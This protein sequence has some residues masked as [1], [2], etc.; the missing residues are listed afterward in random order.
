MK[1][2]LVIQLARF[3]D[4]IQTKRLLA[5]LCA[6]EDATVHLCVDASLEALARLVYPGVEVH[7]IMAH[8]TGLNGREATLRVLTNNRRT[9][10]ALAST[11]FETVYNL[12]F[13]GLNFRLAALFDPDRVEGYAWKNGQEMT[14]TWPAM[15]MRWTNYR[16]IGM[17][18]VDF[19]AGYCPDRIAPDTVNPEATPKGGG[20]GVV[21]AGRESRRSLPA[22]LLARMTSTMAGIRASNRIVL[23]GGQSEHKAGQEVL[24]NLPTGLS[25]KTENLAGKTDWHSLT[26]IVGSL[27]VLLTP[28]TG[29]MHLAA[30]LGTP[31]TA[32]FLSSAWCFETGPY[33]RGH[34]V[35]QA[36]RDCLPCL[37][38]APCPLDIACL[39]G[40][41]DPGF[42]RLLATRNP[43]RVPEGI[44]GFDSYFDNLGQLYVPFAGEDV[45]APQRNE[46]R[47]FLHQYQSGEN[48]GVTHADHVFAHQFFMEKDWMADK[49]HVN[50]IG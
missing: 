35:Y 10:D 4:L 25:D 23:L 24:K 32:F 26:D 1:H 11:D 13:S 38:S 45:N 34:T 50:S 48:L 22:P 37:E 39:G 18:L 3:G 40:F 47:R 29:T 31:V 9:F 20:I 14:T 36:V 19:W 46:F 21:L 27:D 7:P 28:D 16:R 33:G 41:A 5:T 12:N 2:Y 42:Q 15:A 17:N 43:S 6:R 49:Q 30:H 44:I 8:G